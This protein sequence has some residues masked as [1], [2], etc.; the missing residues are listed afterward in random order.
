[1]QG[2]VFHCSYWQGRM[3]LEPDCAVADKAAAV[4]VIAGQLEP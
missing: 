1:M 3:T 4:A 2:D